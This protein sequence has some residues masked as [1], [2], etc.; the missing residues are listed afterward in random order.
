MQLAGR[1][2]APTYKEVAKKALNSLFFNVT[3]TRTA[4]S[5]TKS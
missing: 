2:Y 5:H 3:K 1:L 4:D